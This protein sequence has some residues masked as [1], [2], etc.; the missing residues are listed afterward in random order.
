MEA[1]NTIARAVLLNDATI[2]PQGAPTVEILS[3]AKI[4]LKAGQTLDGLGGY[5]LY[6][7]LE[8]AEVATAQ[9]L[10]PFGVAEGCTMKRDVARDQVL[11]YDDVELPVGRVIDRLRA[12]QQAL[13][14]DQANFA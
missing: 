2:A 9:K 11:T 5:T 1:P 4:D 8:N 10:L 14:V 12:E 7:Q 3:T 13:S 6:G